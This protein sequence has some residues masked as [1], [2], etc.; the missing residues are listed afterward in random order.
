M[1]ATARDGCTAVLAFASALA[2]WGSALAACYVL[3]TSVHVP[4]LAHLLLGAAICGAAVLVHLRSPA[5]SASDRALLGVRAQR[6]RRAG[7]YA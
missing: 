5:I 6:A 3:K 4:A 2:L 1:F 7:S